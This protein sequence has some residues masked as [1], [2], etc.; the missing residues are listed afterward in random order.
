MARFTEWCPELEA[1]LSE[2]FPREHHAQKDRKGT[3]VTTRHYVARLNELVG[4][5]GWSMEPVV[6]FHSGNKLG[7]AVGVTVLGV[8][9]WNV[10]DEM[11][12]HGE[13]GEDGK[14]RDFGSSSTNSWA[15]SF[16]RCMAY[17]FGM[18][19]YLYDKDWTKQYLAGRAPASNGAAE[20]AADNASRTKLAALLE[21]L[22]GAPLTDDVR[23]IADNAVVLAEK[24][25]PQ[26]RVD[27][28]IKWA[29][30]L[31]NELEAKV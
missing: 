11:E 20:K 7:L 21:R 10:G 31:L 22:A 18:G 3:F 15:Q 9:K 24:G 14:V 6:S 12:D 13:P 23:T 1:A 30:E 29:K 2:P 28:A 8:T 17:G 16:K 5:G 25:G 26:S 19:L 27:G 4:V